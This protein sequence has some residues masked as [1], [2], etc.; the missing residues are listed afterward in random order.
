MFFKNIWRKWGVLLG[1]YKYVRERERERGFV[2]VAV[3]KRTETEERREEKR[4]ALYST[5]GPLTTP[6]TSAN[7]A[8]PIHLPN[9][10]YASPIHLP[11]PSR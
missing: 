2:G 6:T 7:Y 5:T 4:W 3:R 1:F 11:L 10:L 9:L 8:R